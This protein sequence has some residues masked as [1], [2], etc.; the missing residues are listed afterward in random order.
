MVHEGW[1]WFTER[2]RV[3]DSEVAMGSTVRGRHGQVAERIG[4][5]IATGEHDAGDQINPEALAERFDVSRTV[6]REV[7]KVLEAKGLV[8]AKPRIGTRVTSVTEWNLLD[9]DVIRWR[10]AG[11]DGARQIEELMGIRGAIE[12]LAARQASMSAT[13]TDVEALNAAVVSMRQAIDS[14]DWESFT[15]ADVAFHRALLVASGNLV[16]AQFAE[17]IEAA[18]RV[19]HRQNLLPIRLSVG[20]ADSHGAI[21]EAIIAADGVRAELA[22]R[23]IVDVAGAETVESL[24]RSS[25]APDEAATT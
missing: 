10:S 18:L 23:W 6:V 13:S 1:N 21:V 22:S 2:G 16:V 17:P 25:G 19:R 4:S 3:A 7:L 9:A 15:D 24:M 12:P 11:S 20:V 5:A 8:V 14:D